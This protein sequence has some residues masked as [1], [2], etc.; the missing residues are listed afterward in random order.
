MQLSRFDDVLSALQQH[1]AALPKEAGPRLAHC[2][3]SIECLLTSFPQMRAWPIRA[4]IGPMLLKKFLRQ[5]FMKHDVTAGIAGV[6]EV[7][8]DLPVAEG[9]ERLTASIAA[10]RAHPGELHPHFAYGPLSRAEAEAVQSMHVAEH[11]TALL[12]DA[13]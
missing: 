11:L 2:A 1:R 3:Q 4:F 13:K 12:A 6:P 8:V 7:P 5:G 9:V 10:F